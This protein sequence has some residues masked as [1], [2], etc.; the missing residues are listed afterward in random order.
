MSINKSILKKFKDFSPSGREIF[1]R[2]DKLE[3]VIDDYERWLAE[4]EVCYIYDILKTPKPR[5]HSARDIYRFSKY[6]YEVKDK[7]F[8]HSGIFLSLLVNESKDSEIELELEDRI[9]Y[10]GKENRKKIAI[11]GDVGNYLGYYMQGGEI[12]VYGSVGDRAGS[13]MNGGRIIIKGRAGDWLGE[14]MQSGEI[15]VE[16]EA[17]V[18]VGFN[19][20]GGRIV[21]KGNVSHSLGYGMR[22]GEIIIEGN[23]GAGAGTNMLGGEVWVKGRVESLGSVKAGRIY[24][25]KEKIKIYG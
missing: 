1:K 24:E 2:G 19:M 4:V 17:G 10:L 6:P 8:K 16:G 25:G 20:A 13:C 9:N 11:K 14:S 21:I 5:S 22:A 7:E 15:I 3:E 12:V 18:G 23:A